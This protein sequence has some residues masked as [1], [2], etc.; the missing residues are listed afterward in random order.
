MQVLEDQQ[1]PVRARCG[2]Q[3]AHDGFKED[4]T[5][6][7]AALTG[8]G[9][10]DLRHECR[11]RVGRVGRDRRIGD[12]VRSMR[13]VVAQRLDERLVGPDALL[14]GPPAED[15]RAVGLHLGRE[16][17]HEPRLADAR[18]AGHD[19][20]AGGRARLVQPAVV[21]PPQ[22]RRAADERLAV[23]ARQ[24]CGQR[25]CDRR[26]GR[27]PGPRAC[28]GRGPSRPAVPSC[29]GPLERG[30]GSRGAEPV[31]PSFSTPAD[32]PETA[33]TDPPGH[34]HEPVR[35]SRGQLRSRFG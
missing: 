22:G 33:A 16:A 25:N 28:R 15:D 29:I 32:I 10:R 14:I 9:R 27:T 12:Q 1:Q 21:Q 3:D 17:R 8:G 31:R 24:H 30:S 2:E 13:G 5:T 4:V 26:Q 6:V 34:T 18:L 11:Q 35:K 7:W 20:E 19:H 23:G